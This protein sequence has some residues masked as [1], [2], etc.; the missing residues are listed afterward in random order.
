[1]PRL[2]QHRRVCC[3]PNATIFK[4]AGT[5]LKTLNQT[6]IT[7]DEVEA[8]R[9]ADIE[10]MYHADAAAQMQISR[11]TF[12]RIIADARKKIASALLHGE[13]ISIVNKNNS[14]DTSPP[15]QDNI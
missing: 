6:E 10:N 2:K 9:L 4:P 14:N 8:L 3:N 11:Q 5:K 13:A 7:L 15:K 1:M 12:G